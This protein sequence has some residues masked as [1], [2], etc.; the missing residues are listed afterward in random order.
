N[1]RPASCPSRRH[2]SGDRPASVRIPP[3]RPCRGAPTRR[4]HPYLAATDTDPASPWLSLSA[5]TATASTP[6][7]DHSPLVNEPA[8]GD[9]LE[10]H[11][12]GGPYW[13]LVGRCPRQ[14]GVE[15]DPRVL[16]QRHHRQ[17]V[18][19]IGH[20]PVEA[21]VLD[22][23]IGG[24]MAFPVNLFPGQVGSRTA[25]VAG[26][27]RR[28]LKPVTGGA[29]LQDQSSLVDGIPEGLAQGVGDRDEFRHRV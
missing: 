11:L 1:K 23:D 10:S 21:T 22:D 27:L 14:F 4:A 12:H 18:R 9:L 19:L 8:R 29:V 13:D 3:K 25:D 15:V 28:V 5:P 20:A 7:S 2:P 6:S 26:L 24:D 16:I 17:V